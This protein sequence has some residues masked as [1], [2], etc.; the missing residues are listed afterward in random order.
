[1]SPYMLEGPLPG[2]WSTSTWGSKTHPRQRC[3]RVVRFGSS[4]VG[5]GA[6]ALWETGGML[7]ALLFGRCL[8]CTALRTRCTAVRGAHR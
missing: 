7:L 3:K 8:P 4:G 6:H 2:G 1:M 5:R